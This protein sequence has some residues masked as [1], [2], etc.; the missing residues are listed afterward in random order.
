MTAERERWRE[1]AKNVEWCAE[2]DHDWHHC[3]CDLAA[4][5]AA[6]EQ[7]VREER[8]RLIVDR[9]TKLEA[10]VERALRLHHDGVPGNVWATELEDALIES[11]EASN[12]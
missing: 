2:P 5:E 12:G 3:Q 11:R 4:V 9:P 10:A 1:I 8:V 7:A 6:I